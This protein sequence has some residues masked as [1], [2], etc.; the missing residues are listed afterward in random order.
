MD[1]RRAA[2]KKARHDLDNLL[3]VAQAS[4]EGMLDGI[5]PITEARLNRLCEILSQARALVVEATSDPLE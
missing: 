1:E 3:T 4:V 2:I 5:A